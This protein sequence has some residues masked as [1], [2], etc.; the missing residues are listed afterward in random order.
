MGFQGSDRF[1]FGSD[2]R[3]RIILYDVVIRIATILSFDVQNDAFL[4]NEFFRFRLQ[5]TSKC[6]YLLPF[7]VLL[8][9]LNF[10]VI[11]LRHPSHR[12]HGFLRPAFCISVT[13]QIFP[14]AHNYR[15][16]S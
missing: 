7:D 3:F 16:E 1:V 10:A 14:Y 2:N 4:P 12:S 5:N 9:G 11:A 8:V 6:F 13:D 15:F